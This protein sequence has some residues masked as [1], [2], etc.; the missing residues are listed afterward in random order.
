MRHALTAPAITSERTCQLLPM[1]H[2][3]HG[4]QQI[5][6]RLQCLSQNSR[7]AEQDTICKSQFLQHLLL[8]CFHQIITAH[9]N[10]PAVL[11]AFRNPLCQHFRISVSTHIRDNHGFRAV[12]I[13]NCTPFLVN[14]IHLF[15]LI[16]QHRP[17]PGTDH[18]HI[19]LPDPCQRFQ[20]I[21]FKRTQN[22]VKII[23]CRPHISFPVCHPACQHIRKSIMGPKR[24]T[25]HQNL[26][27]LNISI[28][29]IRPMQIR[30][31]KEP[32]SLVPNFHGLIILHR[33]PGK[34]TIYDL[35]QEPKRTARSHDLQPRIQLQQILNTSRMV[36]FRMTHN[37]IINLIN[38]R[39]LLH[40]LQILIPEFHLSSLKQNRLIP[41]FQHIRV[42]CS[43][44][45]CIHYNIKHP[46]I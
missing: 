5:P 12:W 42:I 34:I 8:L 11:H 14:V 46:Q 3:I 43:A 6:D 37:K 28:H 31:H 24:I 7:C 40:L 1:S 16:I 20:H 25:S 44:K 41:G 30:H 19:Q 4:D 39:Y 13:H 23:L 26:F 18:G 15:N 27:F 22:T 2:R 29:G 32:Q 45:L 9:S 21:R 36:R 38:C 35:F 17:V 33:N 10:I